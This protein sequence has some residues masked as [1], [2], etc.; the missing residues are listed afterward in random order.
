MTRPAPWLDP[1]TAYVHVPFCAHHCGYCD[2]AVA[3]GQDHLIDHYLDALAL[4][5]AT[6]EEPRPVE[7][8][9]IGGGTPTYLNPDQLA[10][11]LGDDQPLVPPCRPASEFSIESTPDSL[12][13]EKAAVLAAHGVTRV[14]VGV[15][16]FRPDSLA[17]L[18]RRHTARTDPACSRGRAPARARSVAR[19]DLRGPGFSA[20][21]LGSRPRRGARV[22]P[23]SH[24]HLRADLREGDA[25][26]EAAPRRSVA[27]VGEDDELAMYE[28]AIDRLTA[29]GFEHYEVSN[30]ARPGFRCRHNERYWANE[31]YLRVRRRR[32]ALRERH[33]RVEH[34]RH[35]ALRPEGA[36]RR[37]A[38]VPERAAGAARPGVRDDRHAT[39]ADGRDRPRAL[40]RADRFRLWMNWL[41]SDSSQWL[42]NGLLR[43]RRNFCDSH[44]PRAVRRGRRDRGTDE[45][46]GRIGS[47]SDEAG[48]FSSSPN[49]H[50]LISTAPS[51][52]RSVI[53]VTTGPS[54]P[55]GVHLS[56]AAAELVRR[57]GLLFRSFPPRF[58]AR[59]TAACTAPARFRSRGRTPCRSAPGSSGSVPV[60]NTRIAP[61]GCADVH[62]PRPATSAPSTTTPG[63]C[64]R[65]T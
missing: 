44:A 18:D 1:R 8:L 2:F 31:A 49:D 52:L 3:A 21:R 58:P 34:A 61:V 41:A 54:V 27:P 65:R 6:L 37:I 64:R 39:P 12:T 62:A 48:V 23:Q 42:S 53:A 55:F 16:S 17:A 22:R 46:S 33:A 40:P 26:L 14:S 59:T 19:P 29:A 9:F 28:H 24:L 63:C 45:V 50:A 35:E 25:A 11:L 32:R 43:G 13:D 10:R 57:R 36:L 20:R 51:P 47:L 30:F 5:L 56:V 60:A 15:Q 38:D 4:E 7:T